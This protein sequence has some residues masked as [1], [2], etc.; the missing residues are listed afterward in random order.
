MTY[1]ENEMTYAESAKGVMIDE[2]RVRVEL[3]DRGLE[4]ECDLFFAE[5][6]ANA[7]GEWDAG[8][9]MDWLGC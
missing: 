7:H 9:L 8:D 6:K 1:S 2:D 5:V 3:R 4:C